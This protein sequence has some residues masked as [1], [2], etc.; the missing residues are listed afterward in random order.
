MVKIYKNDEYDI[1]HV[2]DSDGKRIDGSKTFDYGTIKYCPVSTELNSYDYFEIENDSDAK[3]VFEFVASNTSVEW[4]Q[5]NITKNENKVFSSTNII[6][7]SNQSDIESSATKILQQNYGLTNNESSVSKWNTHIHSH[8]SNN[9]LPSGI[10]KS[11]I[12]GDIRFAQIIFNN[13]GYT[14]YLKIY[15]PKYNKYI[16]YDLNS[17]FQTIY[18]GNPAIKEILEI[19]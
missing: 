12:S 10:N 14:P 3:E 9:P 15:V 11:E 7:T 1:I 19:K 17:T 16:S 2:L 6:S 18:Y 8:P 5:S 13:L 4:A